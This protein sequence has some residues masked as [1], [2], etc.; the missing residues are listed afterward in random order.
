MAG[1]DLPLIN[2]LG[3]DTLVA[4]EY[5]EAAIPETW[6]RPNCVGLWSVEA[7]VLE[8]T[9]LHY[10]CAFP[11]QYTGCKLLKYV[12]SYPV[13][14]TVSFYVDTATKFDQVK[15]A[16]QDIRQRCEDRTRGVIQWDMGG[17]GHHSDGREQQFPEFVRSLSNSWQQT[18]KEQDEEMASLSHGE[19]ED[20][21]NGDDFDIII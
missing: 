11:E 8:E 7:K 5:A 6:R 17:L 16:L 9:K 13:R 18:L 4:S 15:E 10:K 12:C 14:I 1:F 20:K 21:N 19:Y 2:H 3:L